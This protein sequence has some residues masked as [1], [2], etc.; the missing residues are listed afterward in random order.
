MKLEPLLENHKQRF[1][2]WPESTPRLTWSLMSGTEACSW[3]LTRSPRFYPPES[4]AAAGGGHRKARDVRHSPEEN[5][6]GQVIASVFV[7]A[8]PVPDRKRLWDAM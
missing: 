7:T 2:H 1:Q 5:G 4:N 8:G 3:T 6:P